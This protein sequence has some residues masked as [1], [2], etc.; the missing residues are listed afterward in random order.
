MTGVDSK[1]QF[2]KSLK[3]AAAEYCGF[4]EIILLLS[5]VFI[6]GFHDYLSC[7]LSVLLLTY[8]FFKVRKEKAISLQINT[9]TIAVFG[10]ILC[11]G[12]SIF[13]AVDKG[14][15]FV[16][17]LKFLPLLFYLFALQQSKSCKNILQILPY[18]AALLAGGTMLFSLVPFS[19]DF[20]LVAGRLAG[21]FQYPNTFA[22]FLLI[23][24]LLL[25]KKEKFKGFDYLALAVLIGALLYTGSRAVFVLFLFSNV[26]LVLLRA[27]KKQRIWLIGG[28][29]ATAALFVAI[30]VFSPEGTI[31]S[32]YLKIDF[33]QSTFIGRF[34]YM[35]DAL[36]LLLKNPLGLGYFGYLYSQ[37]AVQTGVYNVSFVHNDFL[38]IALDAG[39]I[40]AILVLA[41]IGE[42]LLKKKN[43]FIDKLIVGVFF[44]HTLFDFNLQ[45][46]GMFLLLLLL[47]YED[48]GREYRFHLTFAFPAAVL[49]V[50]MINLYMSVPLALTQCM[51]YAASDQL[52]P[53]Y[54]RNKV[55]MLQ[56]Q[57]DVYRAAEIADALLQ[58]N[59]QYYAPYS[60]KAKCCYAQ[61]DFLGLM[62][63][64]RKV[65]ERNRF[66]A[67]EYQ[68]YGMMLVN[69][70]CAYEQQGDHA[71]A[72]VLRKELSSLQNLLQEN[73]KK[74]SKFGGMIKDQP[75]TDLPENLLKYVEKAGD[76]D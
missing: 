25:F 2:L 42:F 76:C 43:S 67:E 3:S 8:L 41:A 13:W 24:E 72:D 60:I 58:Y 21:T 49:L 48:K 29:A 39:I 64:K 63:N 75:L 9:L 54:T 40:A 20:L 51:A 6:G 56:E 61:G 7:V 57:K 27:S 37:G 73:A 16:G 22:L 70:I 36:P 10:L 12:L 62:Q 71:S 1:V 28:L 74:I 44:L 38:Q 33:A 34:L 32:R 30:A 55:I 35:Q 5:F 50:A 23:S 4:L 52:Y 47:L 65:F 11:Y 19:K 18:F 26:W 68:E 46:I 14:M 45:F 53:Y 15:A 69:G 31:L 17:F 66:G 59:E